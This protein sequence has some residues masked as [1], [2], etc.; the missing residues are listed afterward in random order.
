MYTSRI[1]F[2]EFGCITSVSFGLEFFRV[3]VSWSGCHAPNHKSYNLF[4][5]AGI[6]GVGLG[7]NQ[8]RCPAQSWRPLSDSKRCHTASLMAVQRRPADRAKNHKLLM[9]RVW[10]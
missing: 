5:L 4:R 1:Q 6:S 3:A 9:G 2:A 10:C 7:T 8:L